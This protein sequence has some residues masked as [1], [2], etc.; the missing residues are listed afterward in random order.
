MQFSQD[1]V[2]KHFVTWT[3]DQT[4]LTYAGVEFQL[5]HFKK[6]IR[7]KFRRCS[8]LLYEDLLLGIAHV[9]LQPVQ[10]HDTDANSQPGFSFVKH[11]ANR[12]LLAGAGDLV[13][14]EIKLVPALTRAF[15]RN[16]DTT[17]PR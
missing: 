12:L 6:L 7:S 14:G 3:E 1:V 5:K 10:L 8:Q 11:P 13:L 16:E 15:L 4:A 9:R 17:A 2:A